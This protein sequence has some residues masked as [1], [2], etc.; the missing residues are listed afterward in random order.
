MHRAL[1]DVLCTTKVFI[2]QIDKYLDNTITINPDTL[3]LL[4]QII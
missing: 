3:N 2:K 1:T 4:K